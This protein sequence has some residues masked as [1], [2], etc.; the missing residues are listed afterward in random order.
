[1]RGLMALAFT[2][3]IIGCTVGPDYTRPAIDVPPAFNNRDRN[4]QQAA[5]VAWWKQF[6]DLELDALIAEALA[7]NRDIKIAAA[8]I[9]QAAAV[10]TQSRSGFYPQIGYDGSGTRERSS[11]TDASRL[12]SI[13]QNPRIYYQTLASA[14]WEI[15]LWGRIRRLSEA[16]RAEL[17]ASEAAWQGVILSLVASVA[18]SYIQLLGLDEQILVAK[19]T[20]AT[21]AAS[22]ALFE[23]R[24]K[25]GQVS[26][27]TVVQARSQYETAAVA[28]PQL[29]SQLEQTENALSILVGRNPGPIRRGRTI[30][31]LQ[32]PSVPAG[33]PSDLLVN[34]PDIRQAEQNLIAANAQI[35]A[36]RALYF[37][38]IYL[39]G[40]FGFASA[41]LSDL[42][43]GSS[44]IWSYAGSF[45][46]P[47]FTGGAIASEVKQAEAARKAAL[48]GY[49]LTIQSAFGDVENTL[50]AQ[51]K[52]VEQVQA[53]ERLVRANSEYVHLARLQYDGGYVPYST[54]LQAEQQLFPSEI[55]YAQYRAA[56]LA[57]LINIYKAM[58]GGWQVAACLENP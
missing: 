20:L 45:S 23:K 34:R 21:Y 16:A 58:G 44:R 57:S 52:L 6:Q 17:F 15:D 25:Y 24:F 9:E 11:E 3:L 37:P 22:L 14:S 31:Q 10:L 32:L 4:A 43:K 46:G 42:F 53:Q 2:L 47:I 28:I 26:K 48:L 54:V 12:Y 8:N 5:N 39:T 50:V 36:A 51:S 49:E 56:L 55:S 33:L 40:A 13:M 1:M 41:G 19:R 35:G 38:T 27:M 30:H 18:N 29:N 7:N